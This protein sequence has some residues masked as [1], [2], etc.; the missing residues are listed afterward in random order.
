M[1]FIL[2]TLFIQNLFAFTLFGSDSNLKGYNLDDIYIY[3]NESSCPAGFAD[4]LSASIKSWN[5]VPMSRIKLHYGGATNV[6]SSDLRLGNFNQKIVIACSNQFEIDSQDQNGNN[7]C[8]G[9]CLN[10]VYAR[11]GVFAQNSQ[12]TRAYIVINMNAAANA[13]FDSI[14]INYQQIILAHELGHTLGLGHSEYDSALMYAY[15]DNKTDLSL[16]RDDQLG[17]SFLY[18]YDVPLG[19]GHIKHDY[20]NWLFIFFS[21][22]VLIAFRIKKR[23]LLPK[24]VHV[25]RYQKP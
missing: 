4:Q 20:T 24:K 3:A 9:S 6:A 12:L 1:I 8:A 13:R 17:L 5:H 2:T 25:S 15:I 10:Q 18:P 22:P 7:G 14:S 23:F 21:L 19:C 11:S 16:D